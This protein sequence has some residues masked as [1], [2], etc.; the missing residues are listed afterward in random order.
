MLCTWKC[1]SGVASSGLMKAVHKAWCDTPNSNSKQS[2]HFLFLYSSSHLS[3]LCRHTLYSIN[4]KTQIKIQQL[5]KHYVTALNTKS[6]HPIIVL[7][8][9]ML[10][11]WLFFRIPERNK[12]DCG[13]LSWVFF[14]SGLW[15]RDSDLIG[16]N[17]VLNIRKHR[18]IQEQPDASSLMEFLIWL[19]CSLV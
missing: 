13:L 8:W 6:I 18:C 3:S 12:C 7:T 15:S 16:C 4:H 10:R 14:S 2:F 5:H 1:T 11:G 17:R 19:N 9:L